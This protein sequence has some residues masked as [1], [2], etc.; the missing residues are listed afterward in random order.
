M[1]VSILRR[2]R[3]RAGLTQDELADRSGISV[4][5][6]RD[7]ENGRVDHPRPASVDRLASALSLT[8]TERRQLLT[9]AVERRLRIGV[10]GP[11]TARRLGIDLELGPPAQRT[12]LG[13][14][15]LR[16]NEFVSQ[17]ETVDVLW[18]DR[19]PRSCLGQVQA[20]A[21]RLRRLVAPQEAPRSPGGVLRRLRGGYQLEMDD[22]LVDAGRF[23]RLVRRARAAAGDA[24]AT[25]LWA[26]ALSC[27]RGP[28]AAGSQER[29][30]RHPA[31]A[32][33]TRGRVDAV[34]AYADAS[35]RTGRP[36]AAIRD[37]QEL[38]ATEHH[39][40][41]LH[42]RLIEALAADGDRA[43]ALRQFATIRRRLADDLGI[44]PG[45]RLRRAH[46]AVHA[47]LDCSD[48]PQLPAQ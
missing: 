6:V 27:W 40:E 15:A 31:A 19:P 18:G 11:V 12:L 42:A 26:E 24:E 29:L 32:A 44:E 38:A 16:R 37:L 7:I 33:L 2:L 48:D 21:G 45:A 47:L 4:R 46:Q 28:V 17:D 22:D 35:A 3:M 8:D 20:M 25:G 43:A 9:V 14:L 5:A 36:E 34:I 13:L 41:G 1:S 30:C 10:L 39:H 23:T